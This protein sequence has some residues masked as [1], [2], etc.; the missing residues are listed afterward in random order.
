MVWS[1]ERTNRDVA[2]TGF[3]QQDN[4]MSE[5][6]SGAHPKQTA[7]DPTVRS[8]SWIRGCQLG[9][10]GARTH[11]VVFAKVAVLERGR[12]LAVLGSLQRHRPAAGTL[13]A[14]PSTVRRIGDAATRLQKRL[15]IGNGQV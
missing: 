4:N 11:R 9:S 5:A 12:R 7:L 2:L 1:A 13:R 14:P 8:L 6:T 15:R 3:K 10:D